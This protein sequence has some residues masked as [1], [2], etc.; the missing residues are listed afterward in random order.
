MATATPDLPISHGNVKRVLTIDS[1]IVKAIVSSGARERM[2][3]DASQLHGYG[4]WA[5]VDRS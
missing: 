5:T 3:L 4:L 1:A 2:E